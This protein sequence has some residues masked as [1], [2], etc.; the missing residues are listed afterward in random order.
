MNG[1]SKIGY[2]PLKTSQVVKSG[3]NLN[4]IRPGHILSGKVLEIFP[5]QRAAILLGGKQ[6]VAQLQTS[7]NLHNNYLFQVQSIG[8]FLK[9]KV[10]VEQP[11][12]DSNQIEQMLKKLGIPINKELLSIVTELIKQ[13]EPFDGD[14]V[15]QVADLL[16]R[17]G[18]NNSTK[19]VI[20]TLL[21]RNL[22][23]TALTFQSVEAGQM[24]ELTEQL[25]NLN[26]YI[27]TKP[28]P[29]KLDLL[30]QERIATL[31]TS[32]ELSIGNYISNA[33]SNQEMNTNTFALFSK[34]GI[35]SPDLTQE[36]WTK[37]WSNWNSEERVFA[38]NIPRELPLKLQQSDLVEKL[39]EIS[40]RQLPVSQNKKAMFRQLVDRINSNEDTKHLLTNL[41]QNLISLG[42]LDKIS[43]VL[44]KQEAFI[45]NKWLYSEQTNLQVSKQVLSLIHK[46]GIE[47]L[48]PEQEKIVLDIL[49]R[50]IDKM[51]HLLAPKQQFQVL[52][53]QFI[54]YSGINHE[55]TLANDQLNS[56]DE[57]DQSLKSLLIQSAVE[58]QG[59]NERI[60]R[61][62]HTLTGIQ[63]NSFQEEGN[64]LQANLQLPGSKLNLN[65][66]MRVEIESYKDEKTDMI[67]PDFCRIY[68]FLDL[69]NLGETVIDMSIQKRVVNVTVVNQ[70][71]EL[72]MLLP[73]LKPL[74]KEGLAKINYQLSQV[75]FKDGQLSRQNRVQSNNK[76]RSE[77]V[78]YRI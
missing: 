25:M 75:Q 6:F 13:G 53:K 47:Q 51:D 45:F 74:L 5:N 30:L 54:Q 20:A 72:A 60:N 44:S 12:S 63:I 2:N 55:A 27:D 69:T 31:T 34:S 24:N 77:G 11:L 71:Q 3:N 16:D 38:N 67:N 62:L 18:S 52:L 15:K 65:D 10:V 8:E 19:E 28:Q 58:E 1:S 39:A 32:K 37:A 9:L 50:T 46:V 64:M 22:P 78:D 17:F 14:Q 70:H 56:M 61:L 36:E 26:K 41:K 35:I 76:Q 66:D 42:I 48:P 73:K 7:L 21:K 57:L 68:F 23:L 29:S 43:S 4:Q 49:G 33:I 40:F 59:S